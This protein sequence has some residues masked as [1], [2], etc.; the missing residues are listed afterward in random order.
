MQASAKSSRPGERPSVRNTRFSSAACTSHRVRRDGS[1]A[2]LSRGE[3]SLGQDRLSPEFRHERTPRHRGHSWRCRAPSCPCQA[4]PCRRPGRCSSDN[5]GRSASAVASRAERGWSAPKR[6]LVAASLLVRE[7][8][9]SGAS[10]RALECRV[11]R[12]SSAT[13]RPSCWHDAGSDPSCGACGVGV[14]CGLCLAERGAGSSE[15]WPWSLHYGV[16]CGIRSCGP[17]CRSCSRLLAPP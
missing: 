15:V 17:V 9:S 3:R 13:T 11:E 1:P 8:H 16:V 4:E 6:S 14:G 5:E 7:G 2:P 10:D 12:G